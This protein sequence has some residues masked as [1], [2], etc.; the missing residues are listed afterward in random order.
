MDGDLAG[1]RRVT[2]SQTQLQQLSTH[3]SHYSFPGLLVFLSSPIT[4][5]HAWPPTDTSLLIFR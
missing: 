2:K 3:A 5:H 4:Q 1:N